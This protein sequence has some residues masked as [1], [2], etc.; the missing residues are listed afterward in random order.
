M[1]NKIK[2]T[3][4]YNF[5]EFDIKHMV[6]LIFEDIVI[7]H[8]FNF[9]ET[10]II[11][12][13]NLFV[14][15][16]QE[17]EI[18]NKEIYEF[19][20]KSE[21]EISLRPEGTAPFVRAYI[22]NKWQQDTIQKFAYIQPMFRYEQPQKGRYRQF[23]QA[24]I[25][26]VGEKCYLKDAE[27]IIV[28]H[29]ILEYL[30]VEHKILLNTIGDKES[31]KKYELALTEYFNKH[32]NELSEVSQKRVLTGKVLRILD[33]KNDSKKEI[34]KNAPKIYNY[35]T[36][37]SKEY[38]KNLKDTL[39]RFGIEYEVSPQLVRG[40]DYYDET[41]FELVSTSEMS[42]SQSTLIGGGRYSNLIHELG[43]PKN[44]SSIGFGM[45]V[46]R[47][48]DVIRNK[49]IE[50]TNFNEEINYVD[51]FVSSSLGGQSKNQL[52]DLT[53]K[54][55]VQVLNNVHFEYSTLKPKKVF[56]KAK[57]RNASILIYDD[58]K[59]EENLLTAK[60]LQTN[61]KIIFSF[62]NQGVADL[63]RFIEE[64]DISDLDVNNIENYI[65]ENLLKDE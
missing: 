52:F 29:E 50:R 35:L 43:G 54:H 2:G 59:N 47:V 46:D 57:K 10:P 48:I 49:Y 39:D 30:E 14:R 20:D 18:V 36:E 9:V 8:G 32:L 21:R 56:E 55:L 53:Y 65:E 45:G 16:M 63:L 23:Y 1:I 25:E 11:E 6:T 44:L 64:C 12:Y 26:H 27:A 13:K 41:V 4:D 58:I 31:R 28:A 3:K 24:G 60:N 17:S 38:F 34:V 5:L 19:K 51:V 42:G 7:K 22:E 37:E 61:D 15:S 62:N 40:L 33:D